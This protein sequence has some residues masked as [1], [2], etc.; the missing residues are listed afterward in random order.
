[1]E[2]DPNQLQENIAIE[3]A[4]PIPPQIAVSQEP[5]PMGERH[6]FAKWGGL[7]VLTLALVI[8]VIDTTIL[9]VAFSTILNDLH[10]TIENMQW[11][12]TAYALMLAAFTITGGRLGDIFGRKRMFMIGAVIFAVGSFI[13][14]IS[15]NVGTLILGE[16]IIEGIG[17]ALML[18][19]TASLLV[20]NYEG[21][22]RATAFG[23]WG[24]AAGAAAAI[25]PILGGWLTTDFSWRWGFR[26]NIVVTIA[27]LAGSYLI[28]E[29]KET[30]KKTTIDFGG[31]FLSAVGLLAIVFGII[32]SSD[33]G[34]IISKEPFH[35]FGHVINLGKLSPVPIFVVIGFLLLIAFYFWERHV[36]NNGDVPLIDTDIFKNRLFVVGIVTTALATLGM[37]G[38]FFTLPVFLESVRGYSALHTGV[39]LLPMPVALLVASPLAVYLS[40]KIQAR[41]MISSGLFI[42]TAAAV[43]MHYTITQAVGLKELALPLIAYGLG[44]GL[45]LSQISNITLSAVPTEQAGEASG[46]NNTLRQLGSTL[47]SAIIGAVLISVLLVNL[48]SGIQNSSVFPQQSKAGITAAAVAQSSSI[49]FGNSIS[50][51]PNTPPAI[52]TEIAS[53]AYTAVTT[54]TRSTLRYTA[55]F[56][57]V[58][59]LFSFTLPIKK[60]EGMV[61]VKADNAKT[62]G[63]E[64]P[65]IPVTKQAGRMSIDEALAATT[66]QTGPSQDAQPMVAPRVAP[67]SIAPSLTMVHQNMELRAIAESSEHKSY[68]G[69]ITAGI[70]GLLIAAGV[71][72]FGGYEWGQHH[73]QTKQVAITAQPGPLYSILSAPS[74]DNSGTQPLSAADGGDKQHSQVLGSSIVAPPATPAAPTTPP[75]ST[76]APAQSTSKTYTY[77]SASIAITI[78]NTWSINQTD[79]D[80]TV[81]KIFDATHALRGQLF[82][83]AG[84]SE[85]LD[86]KRTELEANPE[87][88]NI[89]DTTFHGI[90]AIS[91][92]QAGISGTNTVLEYSGNLYTFS[93]GAQTEGNGYSVKFF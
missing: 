44:L 41:Y 21:R 62:P 38:I 70:I 66:V 75:A 57:A 76:N 68:T 1:M 89:T 50:L 93:Q 25:G 69:V 15:H 30:L 73:Q 4:P 16:A 11:V 42:T 85:T 90:A 92:V 27:L 88:S 77:S 80:G 7:V 67:P 48:R 64:P 36:S 58:A 26:V 53:V 37:T 31:I 84:V 91:Y 52:K 61:A 10:T 9:N 87:V 74:S 82:I 12:I 28:H 35:L 23:V 56:G 13:S 2:F 86:Q 79:Q 6:G 18:P 65:F 19:A 8:V 72:L 47:G 71:G 39:A 83:Q 17:A 32:K 55:A 22:D 40:R 63:F 29:A 14:S 3:D 51:G 33:F 81:L 24:A 60:K 20:T 54:A 46:I 78:P 43:W 5:K 34:W 45:V 49:E 59:F